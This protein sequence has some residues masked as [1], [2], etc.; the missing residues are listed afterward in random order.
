[1]R[2]R[3][4]YWRGSTRCSSPTRS[5]TWPSP[6][7]CSCP[8]PHRL[9]SAAP[10]ASS[11]E[12]GLLFDVA[13]EDLTPASAFAYGEHKLGVAFCAGVPLFQQARTRFHQLNP[14]LAALR[15]TEERGDVDNAVV[16]ELLQCTRA[17]LL[18]SADFYSAWN[19]R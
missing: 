6:A 7:S 17:I 10:A 14:Q 5:C 11:D 4:R 15:A 16:R 3:R 8:A 1:M 9:G 19:S 18:I 13:R 2:P 12:I